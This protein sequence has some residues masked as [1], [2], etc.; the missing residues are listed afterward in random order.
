MPS[1]KDPTLETAL[2][3][4][5]ASYMSTRRYDLLLSDQNVT[6]DQISSRRRAYQN[7]LRDSGDQM[8]LGLFDTFDSD[9]RLKECVDRRAL[10]KCCLSLPDLGGNEPP[11]RH[12]KRLSASML[13]T[14]HDTEA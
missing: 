7:R 3:K 6:C 14:P 10:I 4:R 12:Q 1:A 11:C 2:M 8:L 9:R 13:F 5:L